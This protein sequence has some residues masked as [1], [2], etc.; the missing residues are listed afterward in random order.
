MG[1]DN[2]FLCPADARPLGAG[3]GQPDRGR[4]Q[5]RL[6]LPAGVATGDPSKLASSTLGFAGGA[7]WLVQYG[8]GGAPT[9]Y[10]VDPDYA[11]GRPVLV[12]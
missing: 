2:R 9:P 10:G 12:P 8:Y 7:P 11:C 1:R 3:R 6:V 4:L 5:R